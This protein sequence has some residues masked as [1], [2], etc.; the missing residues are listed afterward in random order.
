M[1]FFYCSHLKYCSIKNKKQTNKKHTDI[2][3]PLSHL[4]LYSTQDACIK[5]VL[6]HMKSYIT[7]GIRMSKVQIYRSQ[8]TKVED[9]VWTHFWFKINSLVLL[10]DK[11]VDMIVK[12]LKPLFALQISN[13]I[14]CVFSSRNICA[15]QMIEIYYTQVYI[16]ILTQRNQTSVY[17]SINNHNQV[18]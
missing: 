6:K 1:N 7:C 16:H 13:S 9:M 11:I 17:T 14:D 3:F 4:W 5:L 2:S 10:H 12:A 18:I 8:T 15:F